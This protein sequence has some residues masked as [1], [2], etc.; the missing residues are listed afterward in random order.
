M[1]ENG[2]SVLFFK[3]YYVDQRVNKIIFACRI[4]LPKT[5]FFRKKF[6]SFQ[7]FPKFFREKPS[8]FEKY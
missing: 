6:A 8:I 3:C 1:E 5:E 7:G 2:V 4:L